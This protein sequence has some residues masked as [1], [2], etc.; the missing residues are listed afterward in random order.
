MDEVLS[1]GGSASMQHTLR[2]T[3]LPSPEEKSHVSSRQIR[4]KCESA[5]PAG[6]WSFSSADQSEAEGELVRLSSVQASE[7]ITM[8]VVCS[9]LVV[10]RRSNCQIAYEAPIATAP[11]VDQ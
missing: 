5:S 9:M 11:D 6:K 8:R 1:V 2:F 7:A 4:T 10:S 3:L